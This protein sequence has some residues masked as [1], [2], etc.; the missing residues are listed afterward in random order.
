M[1]AIKICGID[2]PEVFEH[3]VALGVTAIG[4]NMVPGSPR[5]RTLAQAAELASLPRGTSRLVLLFANSDEQ[6]VVQACRALD[7]DLLQFHGSE[8][9]EFCRQ[10]GFPYLKAIDATAFDQRATERQ[11]S[12]AC[13]W[14]LD[15]A[16]AGQLGGTGTQFDWGRFPRRSAGHW[17]LAGGLDAQSVG[18][19]IRQLR[20][21]AVDVSSG[22][23]GP[24][25][26]EKSL[27]RVTEFCQ[28]V[29]AADAL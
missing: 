4:L 3:C 9:A 12:D 11:F 24:V 18:P 5:Q 26:G 16:V 21:W 17:I 15:A 6:T 8:P 10:F 22:V 23:E 13:G 27:Q 25:R 7:P 14:L 19:A 1:T 28:A 29:A 2:R 20:P